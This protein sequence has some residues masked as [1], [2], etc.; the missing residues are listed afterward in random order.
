MLIQKCIEKQREIREKIEKL[1]KKYVLFKQQD[2]MSHASF[3]TTAK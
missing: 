3:D 1:C 2:K